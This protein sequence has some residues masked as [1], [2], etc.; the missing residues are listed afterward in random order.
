[1]SSSQTSQTDGHVT[2]DRLS[3]FVSQKQRRKHM[4]LLKLDILGTARWFKRV[5][6]IQ[7]VLSSPHDG[8]NQKATR[9]GRVC[10]V[11]MSQRLW[12]FR[13]SDWGGS[14]GCWIHFN[15]LNLQDVTSAVRQSAVADAACFSVFL[16]RGPRQMASPASLLLRGGRR[17]QGPSGERGTDTLNQHPL[18]MEKTPGF[19]R[20]SNQ[21]L[22]PECWN[23]SSR[24]SAAG[25]RRCRCWWPRRLVWTS[26]QRWML[27]GESRPTGA[28][29]H[30]YSH[31]PERKRVPGLCRLGWNNSE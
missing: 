30:N 20:R 25:G 16:Q 8:V 19:K 3:R 17:P 2:I 1:M 26:T 9:L 27:Y 14:A 12:V 22:R 28:G 31:K 11:T 18:W 15:D 4:F 24:G 5:N 29:Q 13:F 6:M 21:T 10:C 7:I 23:G